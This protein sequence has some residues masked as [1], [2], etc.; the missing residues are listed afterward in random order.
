MVQLY[1]FLQSKQTSLF[2]QLIS[3]HYTWRKQFVVCPMPIGNI[4]SRNIAFIVVLFP[5]LV[6]N[7]NKILIQKTKQGKFYLPKKT[8]FIWSR[9]IID[10]IRLTLSF[11]CWISLYFSFVIKSRS[12]FLTSRK[13]KIRRLFELNPQTNHLRIYL[14]HEHMMQCF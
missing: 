11:N 6:L 12:D 14:S 1:L 10:K 8:S 5:L 2:D 4:L 7:K 13:M 3:F 9:D